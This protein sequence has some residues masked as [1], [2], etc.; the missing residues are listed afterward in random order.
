MEWRNRAPEQFQLKAIIH[1]LVFSM[2]YSSISM[3]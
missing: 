1:H 2:Q 3:Q